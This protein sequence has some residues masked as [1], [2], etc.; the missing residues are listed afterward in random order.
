MKGWSKNWDGEW[1]SRLNKTKKVLKPK[2]LSKY[3]RHTEMC[4]LKQL[5]LQLHEDAHFCEDKNTELCSIDLFH[6]K[7]S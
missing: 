1:E 6:Y 3:A 2:I 4:I 5:M 7:Q